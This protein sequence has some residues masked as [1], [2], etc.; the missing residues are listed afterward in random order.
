MEDE[1]IVSPVDQSADAVQP[2]ADD[3]L[4]HAVDRYREL[5]ASG[6]GLISEMVQGSTIEEIDS[7]ASAARE[8]YAQISRRIAM[9]HEAQVPSGNPSR[10]YE[11][12]ARNLKP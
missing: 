9:E 11:A 12:A 3:P 5:V 7:S 1:Q 2:Q 8:A 6:P 4:A 10:S